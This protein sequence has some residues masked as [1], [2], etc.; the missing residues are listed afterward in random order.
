MS[1]LVVF[2]GNIIVIFVFWCSK[3]M[4]F[5][6]KVLFYSFV[7]FDFVIGLIQFLFVVYLLGVVWD[8]VWFYCIVGLLFS[9]MIIFFSMVFLWMLSI[10]VVDRYFVFYFFM[11]Y[12]IVVIVK[13]IVVVLVLGWFISVFCM[14]F[15]FFSMKFRQVVS[16]IVGFIC[17]V[18]F[19]YCYRRNYI[20][21]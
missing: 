9:L 21:L 6:I 5:V 17:F 7:I 11:R 13:F 12:K 15:R 14:V 19:L 20:I 4:Y 10:I 3:L 8:N 2:V 18:I 1:L 16:D